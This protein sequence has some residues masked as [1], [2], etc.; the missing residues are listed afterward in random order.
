M[1]LKEEY[2]QVLEQIYFKES[3]QDH[4]ENF[5]STLIDRLLVDQS[6]LNIAE[7]SSIKNRQKDEEHKKIIR[8]V[9]TSSNQSAYFIDHSNN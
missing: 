3:V 2:R 5:Y 1:I 4:I 7:L 6:I 9:S 8:S